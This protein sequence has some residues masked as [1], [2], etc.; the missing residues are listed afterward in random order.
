MKLIKTQNFINSVND[1][2]FKD[3]YINGKLAI[4]LGTTLTLGTNRNLLS[5]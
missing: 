5:C 1:L 4:V 2:I 3:N